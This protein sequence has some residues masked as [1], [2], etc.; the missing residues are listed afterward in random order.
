MKGYDSSAPHLY[1]FVEALFFAGEG[2]LMKEGLFSFFPLIFVLVLGREMELISRYFCL[3]S[4]FSYRSVE[5][6]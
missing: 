6:I 3:Y 2:V 1:R 5:R 4:D